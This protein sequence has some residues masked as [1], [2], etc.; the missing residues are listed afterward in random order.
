[1]CQRLLVLAVGV[2]DGCQLWEAGVINTPGR[3]FTNYDH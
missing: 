2:W 1:V 3:H